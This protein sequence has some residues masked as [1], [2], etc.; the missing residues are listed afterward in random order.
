MCLVY[1]HRMFCRSTLP[2]MMYMH[3]VPHQGLRSVNHLT[4]PYGADDLG[5]HSSKQNGAPRRQ[6]PH[7][8]LKHLS[9]ISICHSQVKERWV[10][11][12]TPGTT[13]PRAG[14]RSWLGASD[15]ICSM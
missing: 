9:S 14:P 12:P 6:G 7:L 2:S 8:A 4:Q 3:I 1:I 15:L 13:Q 10:M 5:P 11:P